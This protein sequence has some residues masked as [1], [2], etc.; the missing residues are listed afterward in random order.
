MI[1]CCPSC[2]TRYNLPSLASGS[3]ALTCRSCG[4][5][6]REM[7]PIDVIDISETPQRRLP[8]VID[9]DDAPDLEAS[10]LVQM[11]RD[12]QDEHQLY[13]FRRRRKLQQWAVFG[14]FVL[15]PFVAAAAMPETIVNA[16]PI[17]IKAYQALG[18]DINVYGLEVRGVEREHIIMDGQ[19]ILAVKG[20]IANI[21]DNARKIPW[22]RFALTGPSGE[23]LYSWTLDTGS[24]PLLRPGEST[25]FVTRISAPPEASQKLQ[26]RFARSNE[27]GLNTPHD[28]TSSKQP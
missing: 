6:W 9:H 24:K 28:N 16:A 8:A 7:E 4:H 25:S 23:E 17:S 26:I 11:A 20:T 15:A 10:R 21:D 13:K 1:V 12:A 22:L 27:I 2:S 19:R 18:Y 5:R 14:S 3:V